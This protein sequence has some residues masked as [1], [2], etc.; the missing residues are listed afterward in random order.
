M[1]RRFKS[2]W[3]MAK[4]IMKR[5]M[6]SP[7]IHTS[8]VDGLSSGAFVSMGAS[9]VVAART[10][11]YGWNERAIMQH[12]IVVEEAIGFRCAP[13]GSSRALPVVSCRNRGRRV[14]E[15]APQ[16]E[17]PTLRLAPLAAPSTAPF[18]TQHLP[19][20]WRFLPLIPMQR[21]MQT[22]GY[23]VAVRC[24]PRASLLRLRRRS[25]HGFPASDF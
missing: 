25:E 11:Y 24:A 17:W 18:A 19:Q 4:P 14:T 12:G 1:A 20:S 9:I 6:N 2:H 15:E 8:R 3:P 21:W 13:S 22:F 16:C 7:R 5:S 10:R 23:G